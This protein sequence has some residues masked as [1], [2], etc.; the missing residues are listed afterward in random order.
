MT[1]G[2][3]VPGSPA[4]IVVKA[5]GMRTRGT[6][7]T[8]VADGLDSIKTDGWASKSAEMFREQ[9]Q[10]E[11]G[12]WRDSGAGF[13]KAASALEAYA[14]QLQTAQDKAGW[15]RQEWDRGERASVSAKAAYDADVA[16]G[17]QDK[18]AF[19][20]QGGTYTL[21]ILPFDDPGTAIKSGADDAYSS[22][23]SS[24][25]GHAHTCA[26][27]VR[28]GCAGAPESRNW[29][30]TGLA[31]VGDVFVGIYEGVKGLVE[32]AMMPITMLNEM[33]D[34]LTKLATGELTPEELA[35]KYQ[36][37]LE[38]AKALL[39]AFLDDPLEFAKQLGKAILDWDT[40]SDNPAKAIGHLVPDILLA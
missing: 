14:S 29:F 27:Q 37:K 24:L 12:R 18:A 6:A 21:T 19:E 23:K 38:D 36:L 11:S 35:M 26:D 15:C 4:A 1:P 20:A 13:V 2:Y 40:W 25:D 16:R 31:F 39:D 33:L 9:F 10:P 5:G 32:L 3:E 8:K 7:F 34:D 17:K 30:E 28:A 22:L